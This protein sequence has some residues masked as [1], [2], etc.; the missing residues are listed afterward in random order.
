MGALT[1]NRKRGD[2]Y[3]SFNHHQSSSYQNNLHFP[4]SKKLKSM[5]QSPDKPV[6][7]SNSTILRLSGYPET[8][9]QFR[10]EVHAPVR[11][12]RFGF[13]SSS[14]SSKDFSRSKN[15]T[16]SGCRERNVVSYDMGNCHI[17]YNNAKRKA[18]GALRYFGKE[19][20]VI[21]IDNDDDDSSVKEVEVIHD[22]DDDGQERRS[23]GAD[24]KMVE[25][26]NFQPSSSSVV[27]NGGNVK[28]EDAGKMLDSLS[29]Q[30][31]VDV[32]SK[33]VY[34]K[35]LEDVDKRNPKLKALGFEIE[36]N[37][38]RWKLVETM[39]HLREPVEKRVE[40][41]PL[42][43]FVPLT[44]EEE[45]EV[46]RAFAARRKVL[47]SHK[48]SCIDITGPIL[49]CLRPGAWLNDE[50]IN[51]YLELLKERE[52]REPNK[53]LKCH[54]FSTFF[55]NKLKSGSFKAVKRWTSA[56]KLG[57]SLIECDKI[58]VPVHK[59]IHW[60]LA[61]INVKDQK[62]QYLDSLKGKD[63][64]VLKS[65]AAYFTEEVK[66]K[67]GKVI[68]VSIWEKEFVEDLPEQE[69]GF[70]CGMFMLKY[71]D[72]YSRGLGLSFNQV[73]MPYFRLRT[74]KEILRLKAD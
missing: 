61:I 37:V 24:V 7:S 8:K 62:F 27:T 67:S 26:L 47:V 28:I 32:S 73:H 10:R 5:H 49:Q 59:E 66:D 60:C 50:V 16:N 55:Y 48:N 57:Y 70:D 39:R 15:K 36:L 44:K 35:L 64:V 3:I 4:A 21:D 40:Q 46:E 19:K 2:E 22:D 65:L 14:K 6:S 71:V 74:A 30:P 29:L 43:P 38:R 58:F 51:V 13:G 17:N 53:F 54:F 68:D 11:N 45:A 12:Q 72:F 18:L 1:S 23:V 31:K 69:N 33:E 20:E 63:H 41:G 25:E 34:K 42:E 9:P 56:K 52:L